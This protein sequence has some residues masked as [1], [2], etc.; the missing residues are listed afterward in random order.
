MAHN[1][2]RT[3]ALTLVDNWPG[4]VL[5]DRGI[6]TDGWDNTIDNFKTTEAG[7]LPS[8]PIGTKIAQY[9]DASYAKGLYTMAYLMYHTFEDSDIS[10]GDYTNN[11]GICTHYDASQAEKY[12]VDTS[13]VPYYVVS[14]DVTDT[15]AGKL[16]TSFVG[17][18][19]RV[20]F[21]CATL[22]SD[23]SS[24]YTNG[25]GDSYGWFW[26]GGVCP[27]KDCTIFDDETGAGNGAEIGCGSMVNGGAVLAGV[28]TTGI[29]VEAFDMSSYAEATDEI[30]NLG[31]VM[32]FVDT[33]GV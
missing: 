27:V 14:N 15:D 23:G 17:P 33:S 9:S 1:T 7:Q 4:E 19:I 21:P 13:T 22:D 16:L 11:V 5:Q 8:Y 24:A 29:Y 28:S 25:Y 12:V 20:A 26:V 2:I 10:V 31:P 6:P 30:V 3:T 32:G 18:G